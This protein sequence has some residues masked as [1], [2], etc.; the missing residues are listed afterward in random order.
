MIE[1]S[2]KISNISYALLRASELLEDAEGELN[3]RFCED[4]DAMNII[5]GLRKDLEVYLSRPKLLLDPMEASN[6]KYFIERLEILRSSWLWE[7][8]PYLIGSVEETLNLLSS[9][10]EV[11]TE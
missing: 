3:F 6:I 11:Q 1:T 5:R 10:Q 9:L 2:N 7:Y 8:Y 4:D